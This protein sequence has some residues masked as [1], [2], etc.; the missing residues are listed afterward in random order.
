MAISSSKARESD[1][2]L[3]FSSDESA[4][5]S[6][7]DLDSRP[8]LRNRLAELPPELLFEIMKWSSLSEEGEESVTSLGCTSTQFNAALKQFGVNPWFKNNTYSGKLHRHTTDWVRWRLKTLSH[9][10]QLVSADSFRQLQHVLTYAASSTRDM[11]GETCLRC[12][13]VD[14]QIQAVIG[15]EGIDLFR[16]YEGHTLTL[17]TADD[18]CSLDLILQ[19]EKALRPGVALHICCSDFGNMVMD[20]TLVQFV[21]DV[22]VGGRPISLEFDLRFLKPG[23]AV[24][25]QIPLLR[26]AL[27]DAL[28]GQG[29]IMKLMIAFPEKTSSEDFLRDL[30][31]HCD[32]LRHVQLIHIVSSEDLSADVINDFATALEKRSENDR[33]RVDVVIEIVTGNDVEFTDQDLASAQQR[34]RLENIGLYFG[35]LDGSD[36]QKD[37]VLKVAGSVGQGTI[38]FTTKK[39]RPRAEEVDSDDESLLDSHQEGSTTESEADVLATEQHRRVMQTRMDGTSEPRVRNRYPCVIV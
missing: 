1:S 7:C 14:K 4:S 36:F 3:S 37:F 28:C 2:L 11:L 29:V 20:T 32:E 12:L 26:H 39:I 25:E 9:R 17:V 22:C 18:V 21:K 16:S 23:F 35:I 33:S 31:T 15:G 30:T 34:S 27:R 24:S 13:S 38:D 19:I 10:T 5:D 8:S 6:F